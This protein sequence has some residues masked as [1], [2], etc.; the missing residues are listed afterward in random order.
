MQEVTPVVTAQNVSSEGIESVTE[1]T[2]KKQFDWNTV[3]DW[4]ISAFLLMVCIG[5]FSYSE[6]CLRESERHRNIV[7]L[8][9]KQ[10][11]L[12]DEQIRDMEWRLPKQQTYEDG[13]NQALL[14]MASGGAAFADGFEAAKK[15]Y[16]NASY[17]DGYHNAIGQFGSVW[18][19]DAEIKMALRNKSIKDK[20]G[21]ITSFQT[22]EKTE[23]TE[24][25]PEKK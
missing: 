6:Y 16:Q 17:A 20:E 12:L 9:N 11:K 18:Q 5:L 15:K 10:N 19:E 24:K 25:T 4:R 7:D 23:K 8:L 3:N 14:R 13:Y 2:N 1:T 21:Q 22:S